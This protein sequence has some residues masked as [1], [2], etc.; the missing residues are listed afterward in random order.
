[1]LD[2]AWWDFHKNRA[3]TSYNK[4]VLLHPM[5][6]ADPVV[7][8]NGSGARNVEALFFMLR[9]ARWGFHKKRAKTRY[10]ELVFLHSV[11]STCHVVYFGVSGA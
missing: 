7:Q 10:T 8:S 6:S 5:G 2:W 3:R 1:M 11:R 4:L 9:S